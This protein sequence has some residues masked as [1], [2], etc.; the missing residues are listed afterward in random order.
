MG[1]FSSKADSTAAQHTVITPVD[2]SPAIY[3]TP[4]S[5][6]NGLVKAVAAVVAGFFVVRLLRR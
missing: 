4:N 2:V 5:S 1:L 6:S 3:F